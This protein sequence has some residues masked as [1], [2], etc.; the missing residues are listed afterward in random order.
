MIASPTNDGSLIMLQFTEFSTQPLNDIVH[1]FQCSDVY[2]TQQQQLAELSGLYSSVQN[3]T[4]GTSYMK[5]VFTS[6]S[7]GE[8]D[9]FTASWSTVRAL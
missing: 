3:V 8:Y 4:S 9:G 1:V 5:V 2:C 6:D 7:L